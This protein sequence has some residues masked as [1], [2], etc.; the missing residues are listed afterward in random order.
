[1]A[2][3]GAEAYYRFDWEPPNPGRPDLDLGAMHGA[4][5]GF[6]M[7]APEGWPEAYGEGGA[8]APR[9]LMDVVMDA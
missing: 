6:T 5:L 3:G 7:G 2:R 1:M 4:E 8:D 9:E